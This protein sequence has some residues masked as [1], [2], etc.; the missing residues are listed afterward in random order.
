MTGESLLRA[1]A[2]GDVTGNY[3]RR[4]TSEVSGSGSDLKL[5]VYSR[6]PHRYLVEK[7][8]KPGKMPPPKAL[9]K[10]YG[11]P[12]SGAFLLARRIARRGTRGH[13]PV[14]KLRSAMRS[15]IASTGAAILRDLR[16]EVEKR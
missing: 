1:L 3:R 6:S 4:V 14:E 8:R 5:T 15:E 12:A 9:A 10:A 2:P 11:L 16:Q 13:H 7:G